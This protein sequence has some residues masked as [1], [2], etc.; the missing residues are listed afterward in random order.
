MHRIFQYVDGGS[1]SCD[2]CIHR[3]ILEMN[4]KQC[5]Y[6]QYLP[7]ITSCDT[8]NYALFVPNIPIKVLFIFLLILKKKC[9]V[10]LH[11]NQ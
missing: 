4:L 9:N 5:A 2:E 8:H 3:S 11:L 10:L 6:V 7:I 1:C